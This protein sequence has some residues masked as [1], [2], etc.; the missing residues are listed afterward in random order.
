MNRT[1]KSSTENT[2]NPFAS[3][4]ILHSLDIDPPTF[5]K[6]QQN[7]V[8][9]DNIKPIQKNEKDSSSSMEDDEYGYSS[10][11]KNVIVNPERFKEVANIKGI[12]YTQMVNQVT[13]ECDTFEYMLTKSNSSPYSIR[14]VKD[15]VEMSG[16]NDNI[17]I[18]A[19]LKLNGIKYECLG[20]LLIPPKAKIKVMLQGK[21]EN[22]LCDSIKNDNGRVLHDMKDVSA[23]IPISQEIKDSVVVIRFITWNQNNKRYEAVD[24]ILPDYSPYTYIV[25]GTND[26]IEFEQSKNAGVRLP[27]YN[28]CKEGPNG[29]IEV[30]RYGKKLLK[31][32][33][34][35]NLDAYTIVVYF[36]SHKS[37]KVISVH[38][39]QSG[40]SY[41]LESINT[42][43]NTIIVDSFTIDDCK[44]IRNTK[45]NASY[46]EPKIRPG[47]IMVKILHGN[48]EGVIQV[49]DSL[50]TEEANVQLN[51]KNAEKELIASIP[52]PCSVIGRRRKYTRAS[53]VHKPQHNRHHK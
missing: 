12:V 45:A 40:N 43:G 6:P 34:S 28:H 7:T 49:L 9:P 48:N 52:L 51:V 36:I 33:N 46:N 47:M 8:K 44:I 22:V 10:D 50:Y 37:N 14:T 25:R 19:I 23:S 15:M 26:G 29:I 41:S 53:S 21:H 38:E 20:T 42:E 3:V 35:V 31:G 39:F 5:N 16:I 32:L 4:D 30:S 1:R 18:C 27:R 13:H 17:L 2:K 24:S 11:D